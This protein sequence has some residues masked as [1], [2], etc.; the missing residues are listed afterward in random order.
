M[1]IFDASDALIGD[2]RRV[3]KIQSCLEIL[4]LDSI[5]KS[6]D[7]H[8]RVLSLQTTRILGPRA[9]KLAYSWALDPST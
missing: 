9:H 6:A 3:S 1:M 8:A 7:A 2:G 5:G 4:L